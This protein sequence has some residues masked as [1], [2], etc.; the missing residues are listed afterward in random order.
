MEKRNL[1]DEIKEQTVKAVK[2]FLEYNFSDLEFETKTNLGI[3]S[4]TVQRRLTNRDLIVKVFN[5]DENKIPGIEN[6]TDLSYGEYIYDLVKKRREKNLLE[7]RSKGGK[8]SQ[9][10]NTQ[11][12]D[13]NGKYIG[14]VHVNKLQR[15]YRKPKNQ[16][17]FLIHVIF[18]FKLTLE[19]AGEVLD[20][21]PD[22]ILSI[23]KDNSYVDDELLRLNL[24]TF[25][26]RFQTRAKGRFIELYINLLDAV[27]RHDGEKFD[28]YMSIIDDSK[29]REL[30]EKRKTGERLTDEDIEIALRHQVKYL[31]TRFAITDDLKYSISTYTKRVEKILEDNP[32][33]SYSYHDIADFYKSNYLGGR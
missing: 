8:I 6:P 16:A 28:A 15:L 9:Q 11:I 25:H 10:N 33:L 22:E 14:N 4:S 12:K 1:E 17:R 13:E 20:M 21:N 24:Y 2:L 27:K 19:S 30:R 31:L 29:Y 7:A 32:E 23:I 5:L 3:S 26:D 18:T